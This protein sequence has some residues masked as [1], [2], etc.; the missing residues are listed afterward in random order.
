[1]ATIVLANDTTIK[2]TI[3]EQHL[4]ETIL[5]LQTQENDT[6]KNPL[7]R[8]GVTGSFSIDSGIF[9]GSFE[10]VCTPVINSLGQV[11]LTV[12]SDYLTGLVFNPGTNSFFKSVKAT[13]YLLEVASYIQNQE[14]D[15]TKNP[16]SQNN[17]SISYNADE[18]L[19]SGT[20]TLPCNISISS[21]GAIQFVA[22]EYLV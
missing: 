16:N 18:Q 14:A 13:G 12:A 6:T 17:V 7:G 5:W 10:F 9:T 4:I 1:M 11:V 8:N 22:K 19:M 15:L 3:L 21:T 2:A 20:V